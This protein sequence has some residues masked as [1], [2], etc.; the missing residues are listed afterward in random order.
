MQTYICA[1]SRAAH[2]CFDAASG[3][4]GWLFELS[5]W[6][7]RYPDFPKSLEAAAA[8]SELRILAGKFNV[9]QREPEAD[10]RRGEA[11][12][13]S[14]SA[15]HI[16]VRVLCDGPTWLALA[17]KKRAEAIDD[18]RDELE[19]LRIEVLDLISALAVE[20]ISRDDLDY[21]C[22]NISEGDPA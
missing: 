14:V 1:Y 15:I 4:F 11:W 7:A 12:Q 22:G 20:C 2:Y 13:E 17:Q 5:S 9:P 18:R 19:E 6:L 16:L 3:A 10:A 8:G 21:L